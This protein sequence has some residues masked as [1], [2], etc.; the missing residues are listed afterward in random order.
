MRVFATTLGLAIL[1][2]TAASLWAFG[3]SARAGALAGDVEG[4][5]ALAVTALVVTLSGLVVQAAVGFAYLRSPSRS[6]ST[7]LMTGAAAFEALGAF[8]VAA[9]LASLPN[10]A[11]NGGGGVNGDAG[12]EKGDGSAV[13]RSDDSSAEL[14]MLSAAL[15]SVGV[16]LLAEVAWALLPSDPTDAARLPYLGAFGSAMIWLGLAALEILI[17]SFLVWAAGA[18]EEDGGPGRTWAA[19]LAEDGEIIGLVVL[20]AVAL[21]AMWAARLLWTRETL[22]AAVK[23]REGPSR[24]RSSGSSFLR[25]NGVV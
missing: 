8:G 18:A 6:R 4:A 12:G 9:V 16:G 10:F 2:R 23:G 17:A 3:Q 20:E 21:G 1:A 19:L 25:F 13:G 22:L 11:G 7:A 24:R 15:A 14:W 5:T